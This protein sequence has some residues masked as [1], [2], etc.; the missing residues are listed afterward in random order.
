[1]PQNIYDDPEF[2]AGY[3]QLRRSRE[4]LTGAPEWP[5]LRSMLP[6]LQSLRVLD[7]G[8]G[9]GA[10][11]RWASEEGAQSVLGIDL[12]VN[13]LDE[14]KARTQSAN[15]TYQQGN[16]EEIALPES[17]FDVVYS[18]LALHYLA[19]FGAVCASINRLLKPGGHL[20]FSVEHPLFTAPSHPGWRTE[21]NGSRIWPL[22]SYLL[23]GQRITDWIAPGV[24]KYHRPMAHYVNGLL[25]N[26]FQLLRMEEW[27]PTPE[28]IRDW[29]DLA[30]ELQRPTFLLMAARKI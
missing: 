20:V 19:D 29:P 26:G 21:P 4:G 10:F 28:Q 17:A 7:L 1:M 6:P 25:A 11:A 5:T 12:S 15:I 22:D 8:C 14:A 24:V 9:F 27:G 13:M 3:S 18:A 16:M 30:E 23:T 2:F